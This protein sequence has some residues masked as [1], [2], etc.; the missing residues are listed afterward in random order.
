MTTKTMAHVATARTPHE[1]AEATKSG[2]VPSLRQGLLYT[3]V[4][5]GLAGLQI[6]SAGPAAVATVPMEIRIREATAPA[7]LPPAQL[8]IVPRDARV[9][10]SILDEAFPPLRPGSE[11]AS[12]LDE[13]FPLRKPEAPAASEPVEP[14]LENP[15]E[16]MS[17]GGRTAPRWLV[18]TL[19]RAAEKTGVD[20][21]YL[22][23]LAD[24]ESSLEPQAKAPT[25]S[26]EGLFQFIDQTWLEVLYHHADAHGF[27]GAAE[28]V[29]MAD[30]EVVVAD[31]SKRAWLFGLKRDPYLAALMA[32]EL[33]MD[34]QRELQAQ[35]ERELA[36]AELYLAH[37]F[38]AKAAVRFLKVLDEQPDAVAARLFPKA[39][40]ANLGLFSE[41]KGRK[42]RSITVAELYD[43]IDTKIIRR[44]N[45][46]DV[47]ATK[48]ALPVLPKAA[49]AFTA[50]AA[51][52]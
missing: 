25:S 51:P 27:A 10:A 15:D 39:A 41:R 20:P 24:V 52:F 33:I 36:E 12:L 32:G 34:V 35:G 17:F 16:L 42:R 48:P 5:T 21:V 1:V 50:S 49:S 29:R 2:F 47:V 22:M 28:A 19:V 31:E 13:A 7:I 45:R 37:F 38:G 9:I 46:Y 23:T 11:I 18:S 40:K 30:D 43:R 44:L 14:V 26:A 8:A 4:L 6:V 3:F